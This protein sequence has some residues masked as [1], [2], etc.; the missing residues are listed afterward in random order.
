MIE[1]YASQTALDAHMASKAV[2]DLIAFFG[3]NPTLFGGAPTVTTSETSSAFTR[4]EAAKATDPF[5]TYA[6]IEYKEGKRAEAL[7]GWKNVASETETNEPKTLS[8]NIYKNKDHPETIKTLEVYA[9]QTYFK[10]VHVPSN[11]VQ[12]NLKRYGNEIRVSLKHAFLKLVAG[13]LAKEKAAS[14][15]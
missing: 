15:L 5:I 3:A 8:Y 14:N 6:S 11:A 1:E 12:Q 10:E 7:G 2:T 13:Y 9:D 4:P